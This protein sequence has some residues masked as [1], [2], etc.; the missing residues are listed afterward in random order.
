MASTPFLPQLKDS[1]FFTSSMPGQWHNSK[2]ALDQIKKNLKH[3]SERIS[4]EINSIPN[5]WAHAMLFRKALDNSDA[6]NH[7]STRYVDEW[8]GL[9]AIF[10]L[11]NVLDL[12]IETKV[13]QTKDASNL[14][15]IYLDLK[16][17]LNE[18]RDLQDA[19]WEE[20]VLF[21]FRG[22]EFP[23]AMASPY[24][25]LCG[26]GQY[27][28]RLPVGI[29]P[30]LGNDLRLKDPTSGSF[31]NPNTR[32]LLAN[33][34]FALHESVSNRCT[35]Q[36]L[37]EQIKRFMAQLKVQAFDPNCLAN[38]RELDSIPACY[39]MISK[40]AEVAALNLDREYTTI[41]R[42]EDPGHTAV[43]FVEE[44][45]ESAFPAGVTSNSIYIN[46][47]H[48]TLA[49]AI[50]KLK[51]GQYLPDRISASE[52]FLDKVV[53]LE[54]RT[55]LGYEGFHM[56][57]VRGG[58]NPMYA[59]LPF[60]DRAVEVFPVEYIRENVEIKSD[61]GQVPGEITI[62]VRILMSG[63]N[64]N[65]IA[66]LCT[67]KY[68]AERIKVV[69]MNKKFAL[70]IFPNYSSE[71]WKENYVYQTLSEDDRI[72]FAINGKEMV[73]LVD[74]VEYSDDSGR[75][76]VS[77]FDK[78]KKFIDVV[79]RDEFTKT[80]EKVGKIMFK[81]NVLKGLINN[82]NDKVE[83]QIAIDFGT[84]GTMAYYRREMSAEIK[85]FEPRGMAVNMNYSANLDLSVRLGFVGA[86]D[87]MPINSTYIRK[88]NRSKS[89]LDSNDDSS[90]L[91]VAG[92]YANIRP[93]DMKPN[94]IMNYFGFEKPLQIYR[95]LKWSNV[96]DELIN[97]EKF[98]G[99]LI[100][101]TIAQFYADGY[102]KFKFFFSYPTA[103][104]DNTRNNY[105][106]ACRKALANV[107][108]SIEDITIVDAIRVEKGGTQETNI[109]DR[110]S[111]QNEEYRMIRQSESIATASYFS[112]DKEIA[113]MRSLMIDIGGGTT[114]V[115][116][117]IDRA[118]YPVS[119]KLAGRDIFTSVLA[120]HQGWGSEQDFQVA[121][122]AS[123]IL[124]SS[125]LMAEDPRFLKLKYLITLGVTGLFYQ[126]GEQYRK[127]A[128]QV[129]ADGNRGKV[130]MYLGGRG[131]NILM[132]VNPSPTAGRIENPVVRLLDDTLML[133]AHP[134][135]SL[136]DVRGR[137]DEQCVMTNVTVSTKMKHEVAQG[138]LFDAYMAEQAERESRFTIEARRD[139]VLGCN[140]L[141]LAGQ[142]KFS[143]DMVADS[144]LYS[145]IDDDSRFD[146]EPLKRIHS[147]ANDYM[148]RNCARWVGQRELEASTLDTLQ[149]QLMSTVKK[150]KS[151]ER[152]VN[153]DRVERP[154]SL[155]NVAIKSYIL[156][157]AETF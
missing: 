68:D 113:T 46:S 135:W 2:D 136:E 58:E 76:I 13:A 30:W 138:M 69:R 99:S 105:M 75:H 18:E 156:K 137:A 79:Y 145:R 96:R 52:I 147:L 121:Q 115:S 77:K 61:G 125:S 57:Q 4:G 97:R 73:N 53:L 93:V 110:E 102:R 1:T 41:M 143:Q 142:V 87:V 14:M 86:E 15:Q 123:D 22:Q 12:P 130:S 144:E 35:N 10:A 49:N 85:Q 71:K 100:L 47:D 154:E 7:W 29:I 20:A 109:G 80:E 146:L 37:L 129:L 155:L 98:I 26:P 140:V 128:L 24:T 78:I 112:M 139:Y 118:Q 28:R 107:K 153:G 116:Y 89:G 50:T 65:K 74:M 157:I 56:L 21:R 48:E 84:T 150:Y 32:Q 60:S 8:R 9:L 62:K 66:H 33:W 40:A 92:N 45:L 111:G 59:V 88:M 103:M 51:A 104:A 134:G 132:W 117:W 34:L 119:F 25:V 148:S 63:P 120:R 31:L 141:G 43:A 42:F 149:Q 55:D 11:R 70:K 122:H 17:S 114:D 91:I 16:P 106:D 64:G 39:S 5:V 6:Q 126:V 54:N 95:D 44:G 108:K 27:I 127:G 38:E 124:K 94:E 81:E 19:S 101:A 152:S 133:A 131:A 36:R 67:K 23:F 3:P 82:A 151:G 72:V 83:M 90:H